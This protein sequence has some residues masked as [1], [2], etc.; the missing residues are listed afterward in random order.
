MFFLITLSFNTNL[1]Q[2]TIG[3]ATTDMYENPIDYM[4]PM[5]DG[6]K[7]ATNVYLPKGFVD[8]MPTLL[9]R[10]PYSRESFWG[11][12]RGFYDNQIL[13]SLQ[14]LRLPRQTHYVFH[15]DEESVPML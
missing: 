15:Q 4:V 13:Q 9:I 5:R 12:Q 8:P 2:P 6:I 3:D 1:I 14:F 10:T 11:A 7:L